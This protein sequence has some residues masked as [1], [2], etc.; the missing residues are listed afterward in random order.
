MSGTE[1]FDALHV[2]AFYH[3][4]C[5]YMTLWPAVDE[6]EDQSTVTGDCL[7]WA[8]VVGVVEEYAF[9]CRRNFQPGRELDTLCRC[10]RLFVV[11]VFEDACP[12]TEKG[13]AEI[14]LCLSDLM[15]GSR[16]LREECEGKKE[17]TG[18]R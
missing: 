5:A 16:Y 3:G 11:A 9:G 13:L 10:R 12:V 6:V 2:E 14:G 1:C 8:V 18:E 17:D 4:L 7:R 15:R